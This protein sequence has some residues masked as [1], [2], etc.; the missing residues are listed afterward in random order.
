V[1]VK[2][3]AKVRAFEAGDG[4]ELRELLHPERDP[5]ALGYSLAHAVVRPGRAT[6]P[7]TLSRTEVYYI[8]DGRGLMHAGDEVQPVRAGHAVH[9][10]PGTTQWIENTGN[11]GLAF[12]CIVDPP[13]VPACEV[14]HEQAP[15][16]G[17][18]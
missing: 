7:H 4:S 14:V 1:L 8:V 12:L 3:L 15:P 10:P 18:R 5:A 16:G 9:I 13:W 11:V 6:I 17:G 2:D